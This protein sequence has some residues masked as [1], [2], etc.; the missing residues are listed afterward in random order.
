MFSKA[1][2]TPIAHKQ[3][4]NTEKAVMKNQRVQILK[5]KVVRQAEDHIMEVTDHCTSLPKVMYGLSWGVH[6][7]IYFSVRYDGVVFYSP[8]TP[9][10]TQQNIAKI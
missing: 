5:A 10:S 4:K 9:I 2:M 6:I 3:P 1:T 8:S 7:V